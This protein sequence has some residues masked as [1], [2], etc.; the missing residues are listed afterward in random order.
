LLVKCG[1]SYENDGD[2]ARVGFGVWV[3]GLTALTDEIDTMEN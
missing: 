2:E 1:A 3:W